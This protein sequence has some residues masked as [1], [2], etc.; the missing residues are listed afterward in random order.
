M[1]NTK[2]TIKMHPKYNDTDMNAVKCD[3]KKHT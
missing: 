1:T 2:W 3:N